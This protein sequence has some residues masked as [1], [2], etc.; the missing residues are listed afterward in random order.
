MATVLELLS[1]PPSSLS[2]AAIRLMLMGTKEARC[3][4]L[5]RFQILRT[6]TG[7]QLYTQNERTSGIFV[8]L[9]QASI[10]RLSSQLK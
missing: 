8:G 1:F 6:H 5:E 7:D 4:G 10:T 2:F 9:S 3:Y